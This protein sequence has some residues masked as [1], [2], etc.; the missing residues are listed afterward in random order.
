[1]TVMDIKGIGKRI[2]EHR[3]KRNLT[4]GEL[5]N[6][7]CKSVR[8]I[9]KYELGEVT[10]SLEVIEEIS[11]VLDV[12]VNELLGVSFTANK[13]H[14]FSDIELIDELRRRASERRDNDGN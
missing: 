12:D 1:M 14:N 3:K 7:I 2:S 8:M 6:L 5:G 13:L 9:Q 11:N 10:P 4:Q